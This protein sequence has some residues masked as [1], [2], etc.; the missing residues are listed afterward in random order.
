LHHGILLYIN[1]LEK[2]GFENSFEDNPVPPCPSSYGICPEN[3]G[4]DLPSLRK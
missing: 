2:R 3:K 4:V 1:L